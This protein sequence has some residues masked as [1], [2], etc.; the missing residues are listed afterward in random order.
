MMR[1]RM[2]WI[3]GV[4]TAVAVALFVFGRAEAGTTGTI[5][6]TVRDA[7][8]GEPVALANVMI[9]ALRRGAVTD[10]QG[11]FVIL[12]LPPGRYTVRV[13]LLGYVPQVHE[14]VDVIQDFATQ[15][16]LSIQ[17]TVLQNVKEV[18]VKAERPLIQRDMTAST[19]FITG[20]EIQ[21]QPLRGYQDAVAQQA[22]VVKFNVANLGL[23]GGTAT[24]EALNS[25]ALIL[26]GGRPDEVAYY[27]DGFSQQDPLT[28]I[29]T[30]LINNDAIDE[31]VVMTGGFNAEYGRVNSGA[32]N[33]VTREGGDHYF[34]SF[35]GL[36]D[37][38][39]LGGI[40][41]TRRRDNNVYSATVGGPISPKY[42][43][44]TFYFSGERDWD[45]DRS[46][47][48]VTVD[49]G[50][51]GQ[52]G[53]FGNGVLPAN[54][55]DAWITN[56]KLAWKPSPLMTLRLGGTYNRNDWSQ[57][58][59]AYR[60]DLAHTP[61][62]Q[63]T[64]YSGYMTWNHSL[65]NKAFY[66]VKA[67]YFLTDR[68]RGDGLYF[69]DLRA[70]SRPDGD[71][72]YDPTEALFWYGPDNPG[73]A[74]VWDDYLHRNSSYY[75]LAAN[76]ANQVSH[77]LQI[78]VGG[79]YQRHTLRYYDHY[80][81]TQLYDP[82]QPGGIGNVLDVDHY[83]Y[84]AF[85]HVQDGGL[86]GAKHPKN[87]SLYAQGKYERLGLVVNAGLRW[88]Y[89]TPATRALKSDTQPLDPT[90]I[91]DTSLQPSDLEPSKVYNRISPRLGVGFPVTDQTLIHVNYGKFFQQPDLQDLYVSYAFLEHKLRTGGYYVAFGN[92]N[93]KPEETTG[94]E[95][96][97]AHTPTDRSRIEVS[98]YY[99]DVK[100]LVEVTNIASAPNNFAS[101][102]NRDFATLKGIDVS[103]TLRRTGHVAFNASYSLGYA[104]G[105]GSISQTQRNIAW[106]A[107]ET[108]K[109]ASPLAYDQRH[110]F[111]A[112]LDYRYGPGEGPKLGGTPI[113]ENAGVNVLFNAGSG[114]AYTPTKTFNEVTLAAVASEPSGPINSQYG[115]WTVS[116]DMKL[117]KSVR[118]YGQDL[119]FYLWILNVF[120]RRNV[121]TV[122]SSTGTAESTGW[123]DTPAGQ[124][125]LQAVPD[126][127]D[128][129]RL[130]EDNPNLYYN[131][132]LIRFGARWSF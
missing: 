26:R 53:F 10:A 51:P 98:A 63:D 62:Y 61:R 9:P 131:P 87:A 104:D 17:S 37:N 69:K 8:T 92:P 40:G 66:E 7:G 46:P 78:K 27:V 45:R 16:D 82:T 95:I 15:L 52:P 4:A 71:P 114:T 85:G 35:E 76:Y 83:G 109:L 41:S 118:M 75:G 79:D 106:T 91:G 113:L 94:Y 86:D 119:N 120:D 64:N 112:N 1:P 124:A 58:L 129:Y 111:S 28:G 48:P 132:R 122:Y 99:K 127:A 97:I 31:I 117:D 2:R 74:H 67:N 33:I 55:S 44:L 6:G 36:T 84:D 107:S 123:L 70:Y 88:D 14:D 12:N 125:W 65:S 56:G 22:G 108:P 57:Y 43:N 30:T 101:F 25:S 96:G 59:N 54:W 24:T 49:V 110:K 80:F 19:K 5:A 115:P 47:S 72:T 121:S 68:I 32:I 38:L 18:V 34:G 81:P 3:L 105:T 77:S 73:G 50:D 103:Y 116:V 90:N 29:S 128:R 130:A 20:D 89:L 13:S 21:H 100:N 23:P 39:L 11:H 60:F 42:K 102:R 126:G 93:L